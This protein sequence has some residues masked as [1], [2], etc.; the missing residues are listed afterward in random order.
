MQ[1]ARQIMHVEHRNIAVLGVLG[2]DGLAGFLAETIV[3]FAFIHAESRPQP[4]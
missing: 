3:Q 2:L 1:Q 4:N